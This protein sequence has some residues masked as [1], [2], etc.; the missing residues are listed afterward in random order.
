MPL[1][2]VSAGGKV[3]VENGAKHG[4]GIDGNELQALALMA[5]DEGPGGA[6]CDDH[7]SGVSA[8]LHRLVGPELLR[9]RLL[10]VRMSIPDGVERGGKVHPLDTT[11]FG[12]LENAGGSLP[13]M[14]RSLSFL[15]T[16]TVMSDAT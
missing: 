9:E 13:L 3:L 11:T 7:N 16:V 2:D 8:E 1:D 4:D 6:L 15:G 12:S 10:S 5:F 14:I